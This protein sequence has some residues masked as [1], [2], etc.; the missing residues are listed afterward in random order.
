[1]K[2]KTPGQFTKQEIAEHIGRPVRTVKHW[3]D[4]KLVEPEVAPARGKGHIR[5][6]SHKNLIQFAMIDF[7][8]ADM[9]LPLLVILGI[10]GRLSEKHK[11]TLLNP[12]FGHFYDYLHC[13]EIKSV[14]NIENG[15]EWSF[16]EFYAAGR[17]K[18]GEWD[19]SEDFEVGTGNVEGFHSKLNDWILDNNVSGFTILRL[20][21]IRNKAMAKHNITFS[22]GR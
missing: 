19:E 15:A 2:P 12:Q 5:L 22:S 1:M 8:S 9:G 3:T 20:G 4:I 6:Y 10:I 18:S 13:Y 16:I 14:E 21:D 17:I 7:M 11:D